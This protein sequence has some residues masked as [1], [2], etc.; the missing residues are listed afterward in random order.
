MA[1]DHC[2]T[3]SLQVAKPFRRP[4]EFTK[5]VSGAR[6]HPNPLHFVI[7][8]LAMKEGWSPRA[9]SNRCLSAVRRL[10]VFRFALL[11]GDGK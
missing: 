2:P 10:G 8:R 1:T 6:P 5:S 11:P 7:D 4:V 3:D 9:D